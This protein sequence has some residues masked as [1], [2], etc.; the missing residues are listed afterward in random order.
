[1][2][3]ALRQRYDEQLLPELNKNFYVKDQDNTG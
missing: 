2:K 3:I 1:M